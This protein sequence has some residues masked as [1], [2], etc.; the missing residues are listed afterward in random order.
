M[1]FDESAGSPASLLEQRLQALVDSLQRPGTQ[2]F[3]GYVPLLFG[4]GCIGHVAPE[5][6]SYLASRSSFM[7]LRDGGLWIDP[8]CA[9]SELSARWHALALACRAD[10]WLPAWRD[11]AYAVRHPNHGKPICQ[12]ERGAF[13][14]FGLRS[15]AVHVNGI[16]H[17]GRMWIA[18]RS[19]SKAVD[20]GMLD[21][22]VG[23]GI[24]AGEA[25]TETLA[26]EC[27]EEAGV[28]PDVSREASFAERRIS[29][30][31]EPDGIHH[32]VLHVYDL[33]LPVGFMPRNQDGEVAGFQLMASDSLSEALLGNEFTVDA[34]AVAASYLLRTSSP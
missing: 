9:A 32:E 30:R 7:A 2:V 15:E 31:R 34:G 22:M 33:Q 1:G 19:A 20:P 5:F 29:L 6:V 11:E 23:G 8:Q 17:D 3:S 18:R 4:D 10:G 28:P 13:R 26:R 21:N 27:L 24:A 16:A 25:V 14:R 12:L